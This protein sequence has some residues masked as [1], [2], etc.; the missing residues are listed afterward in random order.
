MKAAVYTNYGT[1]DVV[2]VAEVDQPVPNDNQVLIKVR[3]A[4]VNPLDWRLMKGEPRALRILPRLFKMP[5]GR[6]G[7]DVAGE[8]A[9]V[10]KNIRHFKPGDAVFGSCS[11]AIAEYACTKES[12]IAI[13]PAQITFEQAASINVAGLTALQGLRD[14]GKLQPGQKV[15]INGAAGGVGTFA[16]QLAKV[17]GAHVTG[18][19]ST[20]NLDMVRSIGADDVIDY[21]WHD[22]TTNDRSYDLIFDCIGNHSFADCRRV[23]NPSGRFVMIGAPHDIAFTELITIPIK[24]LLLSAFGKQKAIPFISKASQS[25]LK[26]I[27]ELVVNGKLQPVIDKIYPLSEAASAIRH[28]EQGHARGK[29]VITLS[30]DS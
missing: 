4:S 16:V 7:V 25:D 1:A 27:A 19:C 28:V 6:P 12:G 3:A 9:A 21:T 13:K 17:L 26:F 18:V 10:S 24:A 20:R 22:F 2:R 5:V 30:A 23:L 11:A 15:L 29:V 8:V 14:K